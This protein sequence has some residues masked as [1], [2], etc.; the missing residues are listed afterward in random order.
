M[1]W[2]GKK[3][4][5]KKKG[6]ICFPSWCTFNLFISA[7]TTPPAIETLNVFYIL[8]ALTL[9][10]RNI[11]PLSKLVGNK[12]TWNL[13]VVAKE[14]SCHKGIQGVLESADASPDV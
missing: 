2:G 8:V 10:V 7:H 5:L 12:A 9:G 6:G 13:L 1:G 11:L 14:R 3:D 4:G